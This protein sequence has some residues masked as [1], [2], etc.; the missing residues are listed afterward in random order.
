[1]LREVR[2]W[3]REAYEADQGQANGDAGERLRDL[4]ARFGLEIVPPQRA[5]DSEHNVP[6]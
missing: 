3:R 4:A 2:R 5:P 6:A 1:M